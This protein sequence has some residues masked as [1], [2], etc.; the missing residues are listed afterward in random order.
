MDWDLHLLYL[1][2]EYLVYTVQ[3]SPC[4]Y[5][6]LINMIQQQT[7]TNLFG[8]VN[9][10]ITSC[11]LNIVSTTCR[12]LLCT[13]M[14]SNDTIYKPVFVYKCMRVHVSAVTPEN[15]PELYWVLDQITNKSWFTGQ[16]ITCNTEHIKAYT[17][18]SIHV[19]LG[20]PTGGEGFERLRRTPFWI[21][22]FC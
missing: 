20:L 12:S 17:Y 10:S 21:T 18:L 7:L 2:M 5:W 14:Q 9:T 3:L 15:I 4:V 13:T 16:L 8:R 1:G 11:S 19:Y 22:I 6:I